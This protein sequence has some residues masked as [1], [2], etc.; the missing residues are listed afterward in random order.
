MSVRLGEHDLSSD[1]DCEGGECAD[2][3]VDVPVAATIVH[4]KY[5][6]KSESQP[7]D[8]ALIRLLRPVDFTL[9]IQ[10]ICLPISPR[11]RY[12][13]FDN[14]TFIVAGF[15]RTEN[16]LFINQSIC[17]VMLFGIYL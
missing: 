9:W 12:N 17:S 14:T 4:E 3:V 6:T 16:G 10:P 7:Y 8:I 15:G 13:N 2:P 11:L 5:A 1:L